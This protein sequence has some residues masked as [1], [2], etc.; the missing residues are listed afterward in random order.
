MVIYFSQRKKIKIPVQ[1]IEL[2]ADNFHLL[3]SSVFSDGSTGYWA[4]DTGASKTVFDKNMEYLYTESAGSTDQVHTAGI[5][6]KPIETAIANLKPF[7]LGE[8][9]ETNLRV[10]LL[11]LS[12]L[13]NLY[14]KT[15]NMKIC[16]LLGCDFLMKYQAVINYRKK[17]MIL[18]RIKKF[19]NN[20]KDI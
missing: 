8:L 20:K 18:H 7:R 16:G 17:I 5:G 3:V 15:V 6:E 1:I 12:H 9:E 19:K 2:E 14:A 4:V 11:D 13:N 10:A